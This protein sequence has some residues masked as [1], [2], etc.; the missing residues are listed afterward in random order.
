MILMEKTMVAADADADVG[1]DTANASVDANVDIDAS[2]TADAVSALVPWL[3]LVMLW[4][5]F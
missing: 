2:H 1:S 4:E 5:C 3:A